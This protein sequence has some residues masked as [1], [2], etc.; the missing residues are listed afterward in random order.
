MERLQKMAMDVLAKDPDVANVGSF[1]GSNNQA[2]P[3]NQGRLYVS[4][5]PSDER[6][7][8]SF[9][10]IDRLRPEFAKIPGL[11]VFLVPSQDLR[12]GG[13][14]SKAMYQYTV[15]DSDVRELDEWTPKILERL[16]QLPQL[17][18]VS[19]DSEQG[20]LKA[21]VVIDRNAASRMGV[22]IATLDAALN[23]AFGQRQDSIIY[24]QRNNYR[25]V[26]EVPPTRQRDIRDLS[27]VYVTGA[28]RNAGSPHRAGAYRTRQHA[29]GRQPS[30]RRA[31]DHRHL[32]SRGG[33]LAGT[34]H[35]GDRRSGRPDE[36][37]ARAAHRLRRRRR[38]FPQDLWT[39]W[40]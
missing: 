10:V 9:Q 2:A 12:T 37:A 39:A 7:S 26:V 33:N 18:D 31:G 8:S 32:Q 14:L 13:R 40:G 38:G 22:Q 20:G 35:G 21:N 30:G 16:Q 24:T 34:G 29:A 5:K 17:A 6:R 11:G 19:T 1:I 4:L 25:V 23:S 27:G 28:E 36:P 15:S 3:S